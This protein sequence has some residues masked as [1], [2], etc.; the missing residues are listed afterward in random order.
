MNNVDDLV[1]RENVSKY[2]QTRKRLSNMDS[3]YKFCSDKE[4]IEYLAE[5]IEQYRNRIDNQKRIIDNLSKVKENEEKIDY[6][7]NLKELQEKAIKEII[8]TDFLREG[9]IVKTITQY[10]FE[11]ENIN[12]ESDA[13]DVNSIINIDKLIAIYKADIFEYGS[14]R[15]EISYVC[16]KDRNKE[17]S[18]SCCTDDFCTHTLDKKYAKNFIE[19]W[20]TPPVKI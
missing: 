14:G 2:E 7:Q 6:S 3:K 11:D 4:I 18:K 15:T 13:I 10:K 17:C 12:K 16:D 8:T 20:E 1:L 9:E 5:E 19:S